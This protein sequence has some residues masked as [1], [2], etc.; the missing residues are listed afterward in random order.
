[1]YYQF[2]NFRYHNRFPNIAPTDHL[3]L[4]GKVSMQIVNHVGGEIVPVG[5][6]LV[7]A[8]AQTDGFNNVHA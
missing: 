5:E 3:E 6:D 1:M 4:W 7:I 2:R 8:D